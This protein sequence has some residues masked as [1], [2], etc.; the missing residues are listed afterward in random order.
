MTTTFPPSEVSVRRSLVTFQFISGTCI[1][2]IM[3]LLVIALSMGYAICTGKN[4]NMEDSI[5]GTYNNWPMRQR[6]VNNTSESP[7]PG[8]LTSGGGSIG[9][10]QFNNSMQQLS[11]L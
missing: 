3:V 11:S 5:K 8:I 2:I 7:Y 4:A 1:F 9:R 6:L 10:T